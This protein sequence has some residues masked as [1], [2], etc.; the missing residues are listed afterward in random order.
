M[1]AEAEVEVDALLRELALTPPVSSAWVRVTAEH[2][3]P[4]TTHYSLPTTHYSLLT[5]HYSLF[6][7]S[8]CQAPIRSRIR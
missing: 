6:A 8:S 7:L 3:P 4:L 5:T 2:L 1:E